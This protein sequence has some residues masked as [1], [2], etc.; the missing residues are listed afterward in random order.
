MVKWFWVDHQPHSQESPTSH[1]W[2][3]SKLC[4]TIVAARGQK[5][6]ISVLLRRGI[7]TSTVS[8][9]RA[10]D[11]PA[12]THDL[13]ILDFKPVM[14]CFSFLIT[15]LTCFPVYSWVAEA[16]R[17]GLLRC[18]ILQENRYTESIERFISA[19][20]ILLL[21]LVSQPIVIVIDLE[22]EKKKHKLMIHRG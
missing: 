4:L 8:I 18:L 15:Y 21:S 7:V 6:W 1:L 2:T 20:G 9:L 17:A 16:V 19:D 10:L 5:E 22:R 3:R 14:D 13:Q 12:V 11:S